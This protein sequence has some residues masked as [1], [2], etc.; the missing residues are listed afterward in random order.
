MKTLK[1]LLLTAAATLAVAAP[2]AQAAAPANDDFA[3]AASIGGEEEV[4]FFATTQDAG[5]QFGEPDHGGADRSV[6]FKYTP[7][8]S[9]GTRITGSCDDLSVRVYQ[10]SFGDLKQL[11]QINGC[12]ADVAFPAAEDQEYFI[13]VDAAFGKTPGSKALKLERRAAKPAVE[14]GGGALGEIAPSGSRPVKETTGA[15]G[16]DLRCGVD[17]G[18]FLSLCKTDGNGGS[19][20][21][22][23]NLSAGKHTLFV[24]AT[25]DYANATTMAVPVTVLT[26]AD[27][28][29]TPAAPTAAAVPAATPPALNIP[30]TSKPA[31]A[32]K[33]SVKLSRA[34]K[35][36]KK[37]LKLK[38]VTSS[39]CWY[40]AIVKVGGK[41]LAKVRGKGPRR[42]LKLNLTKA[43]KP[44]TK[45]TVTVL[46]AD[47][48]SRKLTARR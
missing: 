3:A 36:A 7:D 30:S 31:P 43:V 25:D 4:T 17:Q 46:T 34:G 8:E 45:L 15:S 10:G 13:A 29:A 28:V 21:E 9:G 19:L 6:W 48:T 11:A 40:T 33:C 47:G 44:G 41:Q 42:A 26:P 12:N 23:K 27:P 37:S 38:V 22:W 2:A 24:R 35:V 18:W 16:A 20:L 32:K 5:S 39:K 1:P 14:I